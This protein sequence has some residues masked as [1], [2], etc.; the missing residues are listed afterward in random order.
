MRCVGDTAF[1]SGNQCH[2]AF[3][4]LY[5]L[6]H[7]DRYVVLREMTALYSVGALRLFLSIY[8]LTLDLMIRKIAL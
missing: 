2:T 4:V 7:C 1:S 8:N 5:S 6:R 3:A